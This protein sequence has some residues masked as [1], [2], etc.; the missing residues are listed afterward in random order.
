LSV[1]KYQI[2][3]SISGLVTKFSGGKMEGE[4]E[5]PAKRSKIQ[6]EQETATAAGGDSPDLV[7]MS[8][9]TGTKSQDDPRSDG[10]NKTVVHKEERTLK[11]IFDMLIPNDITNLIFK[12]LEPWDLQD[13]RLVS[14]RWTELIDPTIQWQPYLFDC[15]IPQIVKFIEKGYPVH[16]LNVS[17]LQ[18]FDYPENGLGFA[19]VRSLHFL[20]YLDKT[21]GNKYKGIS[22]Q[23]LSKLMTELKNIEE[24]R[25]HSMALNDVKRPSTVFQTFEFPKLKDLQIS[26]LDK[27]GPGFN[28][29]LDAFGNTYPSLEKVS[30]C[31]FFDK[32]DELIQHPP[33]YKE[34]FEF[35]VRHSKTL[36]CFYLDYSAASPPLPISFAFDHDMSVADFRNLQ[37]GLKSVELDE[38]VITPSY[39]EG[40]ARFVL[41]GTLL[42]AQKR[43]SILK[44]NHLSQFNRSI[45]ATIQ[46]AIINCSATLKTII[47]RGCFCPHDGEPHQVFSCRAL[48]SC[49]ALKELRISVCGL[50]VEDIYEVPV[51]IEVLD[52]GVH[53]TKEQVEFISNG[54]YQALKTWILRPARKEENTFIPYTTLALFKRILANCPQLGELVICKKNS[55][56]KK[57]N[58]FIQRTHGLCNYS[59]PEEMELGAGFSRIVI[60]RKQLRL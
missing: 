40:Q 44:V 37:T 20:P 14:K 36:R 55:E 48:H 38:F 30:A 54:R 15:E 9:G 25:L 50:K 19:P 10:E 45:W 4:D 39:Y 27:D 8:E 57:I 28:V 32:E 52:L 53:M 58:K 51:H 13:A 21:D 24:M 56:W 31:I 7:H 12:R 42:E 26:T 23:N 59:C 16:Q 41:V 11:D 3:L 6:E 60:N 34:I 47:C 49:V 43:L 22:D 33:S 35:C 18:D 1:T 46:N 17:K 29:C 5:N 2:L